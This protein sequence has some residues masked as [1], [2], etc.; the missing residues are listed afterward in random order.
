M[1]IEFSRA[2]DLPSN[3]DDESVEK[4]IKNSWSSF[5]KSQVRHIGKHEPTLSTR[6]VENVGCL[7]EKTFR[8][9]TIR[10]L[11][12]MAGFC[13][14]S[15]IIYNC[16][17]ESVVIE[18]WKCTDLFNYDIELENN[19][20]FEQLNSIDAVDKYGKSSNVL[21]MVSPP[22][23]GGNSDKIIDVNSSK[24]EVYGDY[25]AC[26]NYININKEEYDKY[27][28]FVGELGASDGSEGMYNF[29]I[30][31]KNLKLIQRDVVYQSTDVYG[32]DIIKELFVFQL[33]SKSIPSSLE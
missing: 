31:N 13:T 2:L 12:V 7:L 18:S 30:E 33:K 24:F 21:L 15:K 14:S 3:I 17:S 6:I 23:G 20:E 26:R 29:L 25:Y 19:I 9:K 28:V 22:P 16:L 27:I 32:G 4:Y 11:E 5:N 10:V 8:D 1:G